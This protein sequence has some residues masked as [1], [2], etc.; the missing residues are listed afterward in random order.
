MKQ[1]TI[2][3][4]QHRYAEET[5]FVKLFLFGLFVTLSC[6]VF[7]TP[8]VEKVATEAPKEEKITEPSPGISANYQNFDSAFSDGVQKYQTKAYDKARLA[9]DKALEFEPDNV[10]ALTNL[11]LVQFQLGQKGWAL[12]LARK[13][14]FLMPNFSTPISAIKY[15]E[16]NIETRE[17]PHNIEAFENFRS[18]V[19]APISITNFLVFLAI[20]FFATGW[21]W[22]DF[23]AQQKN[24]SRS[25]RSIF[26]MPALK[27][28]ATLA[29]IMATALTIVK[30][31]DLNT[32]RATVVL[33]KVTVQSAPNQTSVQ[34]LDL[35]A[36][37]EVKIESIQ[38]DWVQITYPGTPTGWVPKSSIF[39]TS[40]SF[41]W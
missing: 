7:A 30:F 24:L 4:R 13:A 6:A 20:C 15:F 39:Q 12:A 2:F 10:Q 38:N 26:N 18:S 11:A 9:F 31:I 19:I 1:F 33:D 41:N 5:N 29:F 23:M 37:L 21:L 27:I 16:K 40:G 36:G 14:N 17:I 25:T 8:G 28:V 32:S 22:L 35:Y 3:E 34:L